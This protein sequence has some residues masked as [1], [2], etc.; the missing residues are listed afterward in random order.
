MTDTMQE[1]ER[2]VDELARVSTFEGVNSVDGVASHLFMNA[3]D[4][5][6]IAKQALLDAIG[7][8]VEDAEAY[9]KT[10]TSILADERREPID[11]ARS[12]DKQT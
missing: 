3:I 9:R 8:V 1:I 10:Q 6:E 7:K 4:E 11:A 12:G 2:L 5:A